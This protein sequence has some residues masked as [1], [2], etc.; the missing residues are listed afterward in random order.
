MENINLGKLNGLHNVNFYLYAAMTLQEI[1]KRY[2]KEFVIVSMAAFTLAVINLI[3]ASIRAASNGVSP[4]LLRLIPHILISHSLMPLLAFFIFRM[5]DKWRVTRK[6]IHIHILISLLASVIITLAV[7]TID[8]LFLYWNKWEWLT[9]VIA[10]H[11]IHYFN[12]IVIVYWA[13]LLLADWSHRS[14]EKRLET[15]QSETE[16]APEVA[17]SV[18]VEFPDRIPVKHK[19]ETT[20]IKVEEITWLQAADNYVKIYV[21]GHYYMERITLKEVTALLDPK[22]FKQVHRSAVVNVNHI[23]SIRQQSSGVKIIS[24]TGG[25]QVSLTKKYREEIKDLIKLNA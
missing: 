2:K 12:F 14:R 13:I 17:G 3:Q 6:N 22:L 5:K 19:D 10:F 7:S 1:F 11:F 21:N 9:D 16:K 4:D 15:V 8:F 24:V 18:K 25:H 20:F 23:Q